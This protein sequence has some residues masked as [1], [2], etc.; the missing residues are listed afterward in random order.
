MTR[1]VLEGLAAAGVRRP[2]P[3]LER[4][5]VYLERCQN[6]DGGFFFST[7]NTDTN[8]AGEN[9]GRYL[10]Y[11]TTT[12]DGILAL[13]AAGAGDDDPRVM[14]RPE[15]AA[16]S[17]PA[18]PCA[19]VRGRAAVPVVGGTAFL[20]CRCGHAGRAGPSGAVA[21]A[22]RRRELSQSGEPG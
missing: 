4:A 19:G 7:V 15:M 18:E 13:R 16:R 9:G 6:P 17:S 12:A 11:G 21:S 10:S 1:Y 20:L 14:S 8:K 22:A 2:D 3:A 5:Q